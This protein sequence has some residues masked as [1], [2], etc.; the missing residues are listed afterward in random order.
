[1]AKKDTIYDKNIGSIIANNNK[2]YFE[3][4]IENIY[5]AG[6]VLKGTEVKSLRKSK[7]SLVE[8]HASS[9]NGEIFVYNLHIN[10]YEHGNINNHYPKRPKKLLLHRSE[11]KKLIGV[12]ERKGMTLVLLKMYFNHKN[13]VKV[14]LG[15]A[16][17]KKLFDKRESIKQRD[18]D[19]NKAKVM[20]GAGA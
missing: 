1:M 10:E 15:V 2:A 6:L 12:I 13:K 8:S 18:W 7:P 5:E 9:D 20:K 11:I 16:K 17:G 19:R 4:F 3:Y 14:L